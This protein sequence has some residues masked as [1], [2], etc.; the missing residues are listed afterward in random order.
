[1]AQSV[2]SVKATGLYTFPNYF[3][4][5]PGA[6]I[7][8]LNVNID[9]DN[10][11]EPR[12]GFFKYGDTFGASSDRVK[13]LISYKN[14]VLRHVLTTIQ[15][16]NGSGA[17]TAF[18]G[19]SVTEVETDLRIKSIEQNGNLYLTSS[20]GILKIS[21]ASAADFS[22]TS[23]QAAGGVKAL[24]LNGN[25]D[26]STTGFLLSNHKVAYRL[27]W[28]ITDANTNLIL[29]SP[30]NRIVFENVSGSSAVVELSTSVP[31]DV[32]STDYFYQIYR[33]AI[34][35][36]SGGEIDPGDEM[37]LVYEDFVTSAEITAGTI[38]PITDITPEDIR[39]G[40][41][42]LYTN[43]TSG[44]GIEQ[45]NEK[46]P[47]ATDIDTYKGYT[48]YANTSTVQRLNLSVLAVDDLTTG[49]SSI[50]IT[51]GTASKT[52]TFR[53]TNASGT[54]NF[55]G[56]AAD[57]YN[58]VPGTAKYFTLNSSLD[59]REYLFWFK[60][61]AVNDLEPSV[62]GKIN[63]ELD[64]TATTTV[65]EIATVV[66]QA[67]VDTGDFNPSG[68]T[69]M[70]I[71]WANNG[72]V[73]ANGG[74]LDTV[75]ASLDFTAF[76]NGTG[77]DAASDLVFLP[78]VPATGEVGPTPSQQIEQLAQSLVN[79][80]NARDTLV[81]AYYVSGFN[82]VPG[83]ILFE[84]RVITGNA[85]WIYANSAA[86]GGEFNPT[87]PATNT[88]TV[89]SENEER[90]NRLYYSKFQQPDAVPLVNYVD[91][92][93]R[94]R[95]ISRVV[96]LTDSLFIFKEDEIYRLSGDSAPFQITNFDKSAYLTA[97]DSI[98]VLNNQ[99]YGLTTQGVVQ[100]TEGGVQVISRPIENLILGV[101]QFDT[102]YKQLSFGVSYES[103]RAYHLWT[104]ADAEDEIA[105][106]CFRYNTFTNS[107][108]RWDLSATCGLVNFGDNK[109][110]LGAG[111]G[112]FI[113]KER[114]SLT[115]TDH[116]DRQYDLNILLDGVASNIISVSSIGEGEVGDVVIQTQYLTISQY[117]RLLKM[118]DRDNFINQFSTPNY[119]STLSMIA[120][121]NIRTKLVA[122]AN[123]LD[124]DPQVNQ[125][126]YFSTI[127]TKT[128]TVLSST[129]TATQVTFTFA[130]NEI[131]VGRYV[132]FTGVDITPAITGLHKVVA[133]TANT[134][135]IDYVATS[136]ATMGT[137]TTDVQDF[138]DVQGCFNLITTKMNLD[139]GLFFSNYFTSTGSVEQEGLILDTSVADNELTLNDPLPFIQGTISLYKAINTQVIY[140]PQFFGDPS[141]TKQ[142]S[143]GTM[144]FQNSNYSSA[145]ISYGSDLSP[146]YEEISFDGQ[147]IGDFGQF[148]WSN[149]N[150]GGV[151]APIP[152]RTLIPR[153]KQRCRFLNVRFEH[154]A[155]FEKYAIYGI[156]LVFRVVSTRGYR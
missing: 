145:V 47:F 133:S 119:E 88:G 152:L 113:D 30:S 132:S 60:K 18:G 61:S 34:F 98:A 149:Q 67:L 76:A 74:Y 141:V 87:L 5:P 22:T 15:F 85:F 14:R 77:E 107:W 23:I 121:Q 33:T 136:D 7:E 35:D 95:D 49:V 91:I 59:D 94:D 54:L 69:T 39:A 114:K 124:A 29:G 86:T 58:G 24:N 1:M 72:A 154:K 81:Y 105:T 104:V 125:T 142:V 122:L 8:A 32:T 134:I 126:D 53:G 92:G 99:V 45:A 123:K 36:Q 44:E 150:F 83:Q 65:A 16:D 127:D 117:N 10:A 73:A 130:A 55:G 116:A 112:N 52:Y 17:F 26:Y 147:G 109:M 12:R 96:A 118:I 148:H 103:D 100:V 31:D 106:Q 115:R 144:M 151:G 63:V 131:G 70:T 51:N 20:D 68:T 90:P 128:H 153:Q 79:V 11:I 28:G 138:K 143:E 13:Q 82:D 38:G 21:A 42:L 64:I 66:G 110:Y 40:G 80:I 4:L 146:G 43:P 140:A 111:D 84:R 102:T 41:A 6:L 93:P 9:R 101:F 71:S 19:S 156:S 3:A 155:A 62:T 89:I 46:P 48:F 25:V 135:T 78:N 2:V 108:T 37:Y 27:V 75:G 97:P 139:S 129:H 57:Y 137:V 50:T 56:A 120:G